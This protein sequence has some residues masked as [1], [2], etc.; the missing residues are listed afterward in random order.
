M[1]LYATVDMLMFMTARLIFNIFGEY[2]DIGITIGSIGIYLFINGVKALPWWT[3]ICT[4]ITGVHIVAN[5]V[6]L[7]LRIGAKRDA[8]RPSVI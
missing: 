8:S 1:I 3:M 5:V 4:G 6:S 2:N 7:N